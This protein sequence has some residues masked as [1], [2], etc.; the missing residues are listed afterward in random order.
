MSIALMTKAW[1]TALP[2]SRKLV[3]LALSDNANEE[4]KCWPSIHT[5]AKR[6]SREKMNYCGYPHKNK[7]KTC[8]SAN[9]VAASRTYEDWSLRAKSR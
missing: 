1:K 3:L 2:A 8:D 7:S 5:I 9:G 6:S 4:G